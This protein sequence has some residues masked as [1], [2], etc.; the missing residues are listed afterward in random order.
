MKENYIVMKKIFYTLTMTVFLLCSCSGSGRGKLTNINANPLLND[1]SPV[2]VIE[3]AMPTIMIIPSDQLLK[4]YGAL[5]R[6]EVSGKEVFSRDYNK[7]LLN[8]VN[9]KAIIS[10]IQDEFVKLDYPLSDLEQTLKSLNT[11]SAMDEAD[12]LQK[13]P[14]TLLLTTVSPDIILEFDYSFN[15]DM[16]SRDLTKHIFSYTLNAIDA[17]TNKVFSTYT[18]QCLEGKS[19][20]DIFKEHLD[21]NI[22]QLAAE[23]NKY[24]TDIVYRGREITVRVAVERGAN[25][26][27]SDESIEGDTYTDWIIDYIKTHAKKGAYVMQRNT[28]NELYFVNVRINTLNEDGTQFSAYDWGR[29][30]G[31]AMRK[32]L[33]VRTVNKTQGLGEILISIKGI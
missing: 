4:K 20:E 3:Q 5:E 30:L 14:K 22:T 26:K 33:G 6:R 31:K 16:N 15:R 25:I 32:Q 9:N 1:E 21:E 18:S 29:E 19:I 2:N 24:F 12:N 11:Q 13:D 10:F 17:Y 8:N 23:I 7:Y 28:D 27:L